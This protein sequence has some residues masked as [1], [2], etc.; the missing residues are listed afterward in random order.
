MGCSGGTYMWVV[1][2]VR[3]SR[4][5]VVEVRTSMWAVVEVRTSKWATYIHTYCMYI[6]CTYVHAIHT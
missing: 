6:L 1:V 3:T 4:W 5:A 2:E